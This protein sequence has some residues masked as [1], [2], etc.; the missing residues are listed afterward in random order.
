LQNSYPWPVSVHF[1]FVAVAVAMA[2]PPVRGECSTPPSHTLAVTPGSAHT[3]N[4][5]LLGR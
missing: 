1:V 3:K 4:K 2:G 5:V